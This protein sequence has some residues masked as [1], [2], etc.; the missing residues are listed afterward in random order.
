MTTGESI[1][2]AVVQSPPPLQASQC[3]VSTGVGMGSWW[4]AG[5][6]AFGRWS[7]IAAAASPVLPV[8]AAPCIPAADIPQTDASDATGCS[9]AN[10]I[11][12]TVK[13]RFCIGFRAAHRRVQYSPS[14]A[15]S[16]NLHWRRWR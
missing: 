11:M 14:V 13:Y 15:F 10:T 12:K 2:Q 8:G 1:E 9:S 5:S 4:Q 16:Q 6:D 7:T 3:E